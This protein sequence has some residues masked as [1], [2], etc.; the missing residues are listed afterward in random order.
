[1]FS[2]Y[3]LLI[4]ENVTAV[5]LYPYT[6]YYYQKKKY[7]WN[8]LYTTKILGYNTILLLRDFKLFI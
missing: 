3:W 1:M 6:Y 2:W 4:V 5:I 8:Y 7:K